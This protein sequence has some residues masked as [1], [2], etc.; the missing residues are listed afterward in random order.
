MW[1]EATTRIFRVLPAAKRPY[2]CPSPEPSR[3]DTR[4]LHAHSQLSRD[5]FT[6]TI[7]NFSNSTEWRNE[8]IANTGQ[9]NAFIRKESHSFVLHDYHTC[10]QSCMTQ[11]GIHGAYRASGQFL[12]SRASTTHKTVLGRVCPSITCSLQR[13]ISIKVVLQTANERQYG[14]TR[15]RKPIPTLVFCFSWQLKNCLVFHIHDAFN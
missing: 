15:L 3:H 5:C 8:N 10:K 12:H 13:V 11:A 6:K 9:H 14:T 2:E 7:Y 1:P 4:S